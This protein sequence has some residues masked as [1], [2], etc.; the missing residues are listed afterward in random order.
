[1]LFDSQVTASRFGFRRFGVSAIIAALA[2]QTCVPAIAANNP[3]SGVGSDI[4]T[5]DYVA[6]VDWDFD[7]PPTQVGDGSVTLD[8]TYITNLLRVFARSNFTM[9]EGLH[10]IGNIYVYNNGQFGT[11]V[12]IQIINKDGRSNASGAGWQKAAGRTSHNYLTMVNPET[13][14]QVGKVITHEMGHY[15]YGLFDE[16]QEQ[17]RPIDPVNI[18]MPANVDTPRNTI[19]QNHLQFLSLSTPADYTDPAGRQT[20]QARVATTGDNGAGASAWEVLTRPQ[21]QD[22]GFLVQFKRTF[23]DAFKGID[24]S[25]MVLT[26]PVTGFDA[27]LNIIFVSNAV[28]RD[29]IL[30]DRTM[31]AARMAFQIEAAKAMVSQSKDDTQYMIIT[32]PPIAAGPVIP[33]T[34]ANTAGK[35]ALSAALDTVTSADSGNFD[36]IAAFTQAFTALA[37]ARKAGDPSTIHIFT[38]IET[39]LPSDALSTARIAKCTINTMAV[40]GGTTEARQAIRERAQAASTTG[41][42][43]NLAQMAGGSGGDFKVARDG[44]EG[45]K[46]AIRG[47]KDAHGQP[48]ATIALN[49]TLAM[50]AGQVFNTTF[51]MGTG[52]GDGNVTVEIVFEPVDTKK[53]GISLLAPNG[54]VY[55]PGT[56]PAG[57]T[58]KDSSADG[59][60]QFVV[61][62]SFP[63]RVGQWT[64]GVAA[65]A[66]THS[67]VG[68]E[69][70]S[71]S[72]LKLYTT[73]DGG[74]TGSGNAPVIRADLLSDKAVRGAVITANIFNAD[75]SLALGNV[76]LLFDGVGEYV[77]D[78][79][80][81]LPAGEYTVT[82]VA[83]TVP[84]SRIAAIGAPIQGPF[85]TETPIELM[86]RSAESSFTLDSGATGVGIASPAATVVASVVNGGSGGGCT[87]SADGRDAG[88]VL[89][90][91]SALGGLLLRRRRQA[92]PLRRD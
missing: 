83:Q 29:I 68:I 85:N 57:I 78:L 7:K 92:L 70:T 84:G 44:V 55:S 28:Q 15:T 39:S 90:F 37:A 24:P 88:L 87:V 13:F 10:R 91:L 71:D 61:D 48:P 74:T 79:S 3:L 32:S 67:G 36:S 50:A 76:P 77:A 27:K 16:Y 14:D 59:I 40:M 43:V 72:S 17:G 45:A 52:D 89:L 33:Y 75:G 47:M 2:L 41:V 8:R 63:G 62:K 19:M 53:L 34:T 38:G 58:L 54:T 18:H 12:D 49:E 25:K 9:T 86:S 22:K 60:V 5:L 66:A 46:A 11:N 20:A 23:F 35:A 21:S 82:I 26:R 81:K 73:V 42:A 30:I 4:N 1:M 31:N 80:G 65:I 69:I 6:N 64:L 56:L 51:G